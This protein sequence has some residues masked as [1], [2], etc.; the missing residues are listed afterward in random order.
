MKQI[1]IAV[2]NYEDKIY[3]RVISRLMNM[4]I[5]EG[6]TTNFAYTERV[7]IDKARHGIA[8]MCLMNNNDYLFFCDSDQIPSKNAIAE[9]IKLD[10][11]IVGCPI[12]SR[13]GDKFIAV[14]DKDIDRLEH[15][16]GTCEV[17]AVGMATTLIKRE[18]LEKTM[19][20]WVNPFTFTVEKVGDKFVE[21]S[22]DVM[23]C[24]RA[25]DLGFKVWCTDKVYSDHIGEP[26]A[27]RYHKGYHNSLNDKL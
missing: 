9:M 27:Y 1:L 17:G 21:F 4:D 7:F 26:V 24:R 2:P 14:F 3:N 10:K 18:V 12:P 23:F 8:Q 25:R 20:E 11:D 19:E 6:Y 22:E 15:F 16:E 13:R 5:P